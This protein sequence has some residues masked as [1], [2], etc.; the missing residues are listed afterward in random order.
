LQIMDF[1]RF[2]CLSFDC[3]GTLIDWETGLLSVLQPILRG[4]SVR[5]TDDEVLELHARAEA[6]IEASDYRPYKQ[7]L[8]AVLQR[9]GADLGFSP[10]DSELGAFSF[11][12]RSWPPFP[13]SSEAL[14]ALKKKYSL[15]ILSNIDDD[16]FAS[17]AKSLGVNFDYVITAQ[18][19]GAYKP[20]LRG[21][22]HLIDR[23]ALPKDQLLHVAQSLYHDIAP[24]K[25]LGLSTV[26]VNR[27]KGL[28]GPGATPPAEAWPDVEVP[29]LGSL[30]SLAGTL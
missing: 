12:V 9:F 11:S 8:R 30:A 7:V 1:D 3:Y 20:D 15:A 5:L 26:W 23:V 17:S 29:H 16:L 4:H 14:R 22:E 10:T 21:F 6:E 24:A 2:S 18:Q 25:E 13:D 28:K 27:R 19:V